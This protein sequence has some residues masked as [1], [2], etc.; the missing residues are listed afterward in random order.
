[1]FYWLFVLL[2]IVIVI[3]LVVFII[4]NSFYL[5][6]DYS[7]FEISVIGVVFYIFEWLFVRLV[8]IIFIGGVV[9]I[10][11][12]WKNVWNCIIFDVFGDELGFKIIVCKKEW[13]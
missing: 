4:L 12:M 2:C 5:G 11:L 6:W 13:N 7:D 10:F 9:G 1:M 3:I 8:L